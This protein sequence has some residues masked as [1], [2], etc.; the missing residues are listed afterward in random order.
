[1]IGTAPRAAMASTSAAA[2]CWYLATVAVS[3]TSRTSS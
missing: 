2:A 3:V 1:M